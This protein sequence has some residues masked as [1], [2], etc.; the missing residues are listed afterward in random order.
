MSRGDPCN[1]GQYMGDKR[2]TRVVAAPGGQSSISLGWDTE[3]P[4]KQPAP[5]RQ[6]QQQATPPRTSQD[7]AMGP[8]A[9]SSPEKR[10]Q[11]SNVWASNSNQNCGNVITDR[12]TTRIHAPPG[13]KSSI[14]F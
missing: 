5:S 6:P 14:V 1:R 7:P 10:G 4:R 9:Q 11:S 2:S 13:G 3:E 8:P 12:P